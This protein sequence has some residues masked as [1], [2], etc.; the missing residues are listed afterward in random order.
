MKIIG[1]D[2]SGMVASVALVADGVLIAEYTM[3]HK[4]THSQ[5]LL[6]MLDPSATDVCIIR[7]ASQVERTGVFRAWWFPSWMPDVDRYIRGSIA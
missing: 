4:K 7:Q 5:T 1:I 3:N 2:S 6:P